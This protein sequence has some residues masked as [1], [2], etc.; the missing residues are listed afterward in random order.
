VKD[1][2]NPKK[3]PKDSGVT[4]STTSYIC[5]FIDAEKELK[6]ADLEAYKIECGSGCSGSL[7]PALA[8]VSKC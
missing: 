5:N 8:D 3:C 7:Q 2:D 6:G 4:E 1:K